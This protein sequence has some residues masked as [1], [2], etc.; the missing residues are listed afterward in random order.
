LFNDGDVAILIDRVEASCACVTA[1]PLPLR[2]A[3]GSGA[4]LT[5]RFDSSKEPTFRGT[6][7]VEVV[8]RSADGR[9]RLTTNVRVSVLDPEGQGGDR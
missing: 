9:V 6:L 8:G 1:G 4:A 2:V 3:P 7:G 5:L